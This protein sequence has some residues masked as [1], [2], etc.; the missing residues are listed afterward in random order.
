[1]LAASRPGTFHHALPFSE[2]DPT[3]T[4]WT[5]QR[6]FRHQEHLLFSFATFE[7]D[8]RMPPPTLGYSVSHILLSFA[9]SNSLGRL[10]IKRAMLV[11]I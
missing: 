7:I 6:V 9:V 11:G 2:S 8:S 5:L 4:K 1:V 10:R 3:L